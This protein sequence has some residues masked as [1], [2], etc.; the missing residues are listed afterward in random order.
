[1]VLVNIGVINTDTEP[2]VQKA[3]AIQMYSTQP[4]S[5]SPAP[6]R[7]SSNSFCSI[8]WVVPETLKLK[9]KHDKA[10]SCR[11]GWGGVARFHLGAC[12]T[13][14]LQAQLWRWERWDDE[15]RGARKK[16]DNPAGRSDSTCWAAV[17]YW[18]SLSVTGCEIPRGALQLQQWIKE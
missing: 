9:L 17:Y 13:A 1:M 6:R 16:E 18:S 4:T 8:L 10:R 5:T 15:D 7:S 2:T 11:W 3:A 14:V 12:T